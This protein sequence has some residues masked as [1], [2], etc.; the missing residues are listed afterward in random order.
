MFFCTFSDMFF[1]DHPALKVSKHPIPVGTSPAG[2]K[3]DACAI[4]NGES[5]AGADGKFIVVCS[6][7]M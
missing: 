3:Q 4:Q 1:G 2:H 5:Q 7:D 6:D